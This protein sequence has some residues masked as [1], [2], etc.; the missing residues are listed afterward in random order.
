M[1]NADYQFFDTDV[2][3]IIAKLRADF[4]AEYKKLTG[5][6]VTV[7][8]ASVEN[9]MICWIAN[10]LIHERELTNYAANQ[11]I[12][13]RA[14]G[15]NLEALAEMFFAQERTPAVPASCTV[16]F[17]ISTTR[18]TRRY[19]SNGHQPNPLL[20]DAGGRLY[21]RRESV[22]RSPRTVPNARNRRERLGGRQH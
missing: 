12:P 10:V 17:F 11:N 16:R 5:N 2:T 3:Q 13:S 15:D 7:R 20:G 22:C 14:V 4:E 21:P 18:T 1:R 9:L 8:P 6:A 19:E